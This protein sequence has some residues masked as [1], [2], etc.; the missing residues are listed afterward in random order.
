MLHPKMK[1]WVLFLSRIPLRL[2][3]LW[4]LG[5]WVAFQIFMFLSDTQEQVSWAAHV[6]GITAGLVLVGLLKRREVPLFDR[7]II[8]PHAIEAEDGQP[9]RWGRSGS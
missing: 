9:I 7:E 5:G 6:G 1:I 2:S 4:V 8:P 3:A